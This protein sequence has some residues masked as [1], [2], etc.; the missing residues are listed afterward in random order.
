MGIRIKNILSFGIITMI[1]CAM[2]LPSYAAVT[3]YVAKDKSGLNTYQYNLSK[4]KE[5][6]KNNYLGK[7]G[8]ELFLDFQNNTVYALLDDKNVYIDMNDVKK[9]YRNACLSG[10]SF[11]LNTYAESSKVVKSNM[12]DT[13]KEVSLGADGNLQK[14][15]KPVTKKDQSDDGLSVDS[16]D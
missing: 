15:D 13:L 10:E 6:Y 12:P 8:G 11:D 16:I 4:L 3:H 2:T 14:Q 7:P 1:T 5:S 9:A